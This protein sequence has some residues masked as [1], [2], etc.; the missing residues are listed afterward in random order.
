MLRK[1]LKRICRKRTISAAPQSS[2][3]AAPQSSASA[4]P[5][6]SASAPTTGRTASNVADGLIGL[7]VIHEPKVGTDIVDIVFVHG[8]GGSARGTW[9]HYPSKTF[10]P[11]L[12]HEDQRFANVRISTFGYDADFQNIFGAKNVLSISDFAK[13]LLHVLDLHYDASG[14]VCLPDN[15]ELI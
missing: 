14:D 11:T 1:F 4:A 9:T 8:L 12:L 2:A 6:S 7:R 10:W 13:Q 3:S 5:Q 15:A